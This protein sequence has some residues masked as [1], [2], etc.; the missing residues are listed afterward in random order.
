MKKATYLILGLGNPGEEYENTYHNAGRMVVVKWQGDTHLRD[1]N[2]D[3]KLESLVTEKKVGKYHVVAALPETFMNKSGRAIEKLVKKYRVKPEHIVAVH[4]DADIQLGKI[5]LV[6]NRDS[7]G[8][9]GVESLMRALKTK[10]FIRIRIGTTKTVSKKG[11]WRE[12]DLMD[13]VIKQIP[14]SQKPT[15]KKA[16]ANASDAITIIIKEGLGKAMSIYN[17]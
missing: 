6:K 9:K 17:R 12:R 3:A 15:L 4:D 16:L 13:E 5:K 11:V 14:A 10:D 1:F 2:A 7:A 8:H